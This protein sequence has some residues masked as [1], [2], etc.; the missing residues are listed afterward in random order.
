[1]PN[2]FKFKNFTLY[3][4]AGDGVEPIHVHVTE[5]RPSKSSI[6]FWLL[7]NRKCRLAYNK[8]DIKGKDIKLLEQFIEINF[9]RIC[10]IWKSFFNLDSVDFHD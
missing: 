7:K 3:F 5:G 6:K 8:T 9:D 4:Y 1:M 2:Y 10:D